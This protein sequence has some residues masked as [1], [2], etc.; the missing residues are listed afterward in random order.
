MGSSKG[1]PIGKLLQPDIPYEPAKDPP[2]HQP[3]GEGS[4]K[5]QADIVQG[6]SG[7]VQSDR[8]DRDLGNEEGEVKTK[9]PP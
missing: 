5:G 6:E 1:P 3:G 9:Y 8:Q 7:G 2:K 4:H